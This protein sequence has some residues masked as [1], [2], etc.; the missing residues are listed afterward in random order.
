L[1]LIAGAGIGSGEFTNEAWMSDAS[2]SVLSSVGRATV[3]MIGDPTLDCTDII[4]RVFEDKS[5]T[6]SM[7]DGARG[8]AN[9]RLA[10]VRGQLITTDSEGRYH[11]AC[12]DIP[13]RERGT[14]FIL[15]LDERTLP[16]GYRVMTENPRVIRITA[17]KMGKINFGVSQSHVA[18]LDLA[19]AAFETGTTRLK[20][21]W[22]AGIQ[23][24]LEALKKDRAVLRIAYR[25][26]MTEA[27]TTAEAR[28]K[29]VAD[30]FTTAWND[31]GAPYP[32]S[33]EIEIFA[34]RATR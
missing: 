24:V 28:V 31:V 14:N 25:R 23:Q 21:Q 27:T 6:G 20:P 18:R 2:G 4:G 33:V 29:S 12:A 17:G 1:V 3:R 10:T 26:Q 16:I 9:V 22:V 7:E 13:E 30:A 15:K 34:E 5:G 32:L 8:L 19:D 11:I